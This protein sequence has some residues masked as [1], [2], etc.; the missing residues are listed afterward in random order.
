MTLAN[1]GGVISHTG[2]GA[3]GKIR[4][5]RF[6][7]EDTIRGHDHGYITRARSLRGELLAT[8]TS[9]R[10]GLAIRPTVGCV[11]L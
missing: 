9:A 3:D 11:T 10:W 4:W 6:F 8:S 7:A 1:R 5:T 2:L